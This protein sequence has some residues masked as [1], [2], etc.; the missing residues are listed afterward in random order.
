MCRRLAPTPPPIADRRSRATGA[1]GAPTPGFV[2]TEKL[3]TMLGPPQPG[4]HTAPRRPLSDDEQ[5]RDRQLQSELERVVGPDGNVYVVGRP[6][7]DD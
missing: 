6:G 3:L 5:E 7:T 4:D 2:L 1:D